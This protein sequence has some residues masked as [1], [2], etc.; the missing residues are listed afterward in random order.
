MTNVV[1]QLAL[2][3]LVIGALWKRPVKELEQF[4]GDDSKRLDKLQR[5]LDIAVW[6]MSPSA[7]GSSCFPSDEPDEIFDGD[8]EVLMTVRTNGP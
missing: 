8:S 2:V 7:G 5:I 4:L 3:R 6:K 1:A